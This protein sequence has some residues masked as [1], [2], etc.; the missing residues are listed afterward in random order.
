MGCPTRLSGPSLPSVKPCLA[1][2][3]CSLLHPTQDFFLFFRWIV[4][5]SSSTL[6]FMLFHQPE[7]FFLPC[8]L[9]LA[10]SS[11]HLLFWCRHHLLLE[12]SPDSLHRSWVRHLSWLP[13]PQDLPLHSPDHVPCSVCLPVE[14]VSSGRAGPLPFFT[15][16]PPVCRTCLWNKRD[17]CLSWFLTASQ[18]YP[19]H[20]PSHPNMPTSVGTSCEDPH[21]NLV[22]SQHPSHLE[23]PWH[24][25]LHCSGK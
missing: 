15:T 7:A 22:H 11:T 2:S 9:Y 8:L 14:V 19:Q 21:M 18:R 4:F 6:L 5:P 3:S 17:S 16:E 10:H 23:G 24:L 20:A 13:S 1:T 25:D 12:A